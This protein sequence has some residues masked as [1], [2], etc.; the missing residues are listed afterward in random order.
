VA[1]FTASGHQL[2]E[3]YGL[4][5]V[6]PFTGRSVFTEEQF[7]TAIERLRE[8]GGSTAIVPAM[9]LPRIAALLDAHGFRVLTT[10]GWRAGVPGESIPDEDVVKQSTGVI[11]NELT[12]WVDAR[13]LEGGATR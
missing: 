12:K 13:A 4:R 1:L 5:D 10:D 8:A 6:I 7:E 2:A 9:I 11:A 3:A